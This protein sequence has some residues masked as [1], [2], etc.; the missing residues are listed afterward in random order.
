MALQELEQFQ[1]VP[2]TLTT[3]S[4]LSTIAMTQL[5][6]K[7]YCFAFDHTLFLIGWDHLKNVPIFRGF[8]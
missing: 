3:L 4:L 7:V 1:H 2:Y 8:M 6:A 5:Q